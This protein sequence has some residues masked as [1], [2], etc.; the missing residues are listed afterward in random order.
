MYDFSVII[1][2]VEEA[3]EESLDLLN[4]KYYSM[5][6][7][8]QKEVFFDSIEVRQ[9]I[10]DIQDCHNAVLLV[11]NKLTNNTGM[12]SEIKKEDSETS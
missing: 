4:E 11:A 7:V 12:I 8:L 9:V 1:L 5:N 3:I 2:S 6:K 10:A